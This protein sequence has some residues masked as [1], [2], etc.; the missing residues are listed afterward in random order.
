M[1]KYLKCFLCSSSVLSLIVFILSCLGCGHILYH[2]GGHYT[3]Y[4]K[5]DILAIGNRTGNRD[6]G[7]F[8]DI[9]IRCDEKPYNPNI[10]KFS[11][12]L[13][14]GHI[15][16]SDQFDYSTISSISNV[17]KSKSKESLNE[18]FFFKDGYL[19]CFNDNNLVFFGT[20]RFRK[21]KEYTPMIGNADGTIFYKFPITQQQIEEILGKPDKYIN[22]LTL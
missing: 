12:K 19:F 8:Y 14:N 6:D 4:I 3:G 20:C 15:L 9:E 1:K 18:T 11:I 5:G 10:N 13:S 7:V 22:K 2:I 16:Y 17:E 21:G